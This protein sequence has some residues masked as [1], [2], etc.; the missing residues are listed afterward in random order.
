M[1]ILALGSMVGA[2]GLILVGVP[3]SAE[4]LARLSVYLLFTVVYT[5]LWL[6]LAM[7][8]SVLC[9]HAAT[10]API[11]IAVWIFLTMFAT[12]ISTAVASI[13]YPIDGIQG[14]Y[15]MV[16]NYQ[17]ELN[18]NRVSP[19][20]LYCEAVST[21]L[22]PNVRTIGITTQASLSGAL[23]SYLSFDQNVLLV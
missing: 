21:L 5:T 9:K 23:V 3:P 6:G 18:L 11:V 16:D 8:C 13:V 15:N 20:Y 7:L 14:F 4:E 19:Y 12:M 1:I 22:N 2:V 10:S 17:P